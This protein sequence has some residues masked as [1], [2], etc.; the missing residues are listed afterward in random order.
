MFSFMIREGFSILA[1][2]PAFLSLAIP[3]DYGFLT[4]FFATVVLSSVIQ[5]GLK[6]VK[7]G[8]ARLLLVILPAHSHVTGLLPGVVFAFMR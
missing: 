6:T 8:S 1:D 4:D 2:R 3:P 5:Q 7:N